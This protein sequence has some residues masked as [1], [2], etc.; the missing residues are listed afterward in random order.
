MRQFCR[1]TFRDVSILL[2]R[3]VDHTK[4][5][6][7][8]VFP[9]SYADKPCFNSRRS[10][11]SIS[12]ILI[13]PLVFSGLVLTLWTW[14]CFMM[15]IFQNKI[16]YMPGLPPNARQEK[17]SDYVKQ[18]AGISWREEKIKSTD[19]TRIALCI[20]EIEADSDDK[21]IGSKSSP[22]YIIYFQG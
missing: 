9:T 10:I 2:T 15:I 8:W 13:P 14:K 3:R 20:S 16:I 6:P 4:A 22:V 12:T 11:I 1:R 17:I 7:P 19:G 21:V 5:H 18:C